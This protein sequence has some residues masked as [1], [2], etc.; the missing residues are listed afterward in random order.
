MK[1]VAVVVVDEVKQEERARSQCTQPFVGVGKLAAQVTL[2][3]QGP[4]ISGI[5][6]QVSFI[7][8]NG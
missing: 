1:V 8:M 2:I 3:G 5:T 6:P 4:R 7:L